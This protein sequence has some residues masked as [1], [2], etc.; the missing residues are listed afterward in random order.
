[1][2]YTVEDWNSNAEKK[3]GQK[4]LV[5]KTLNRHYRRVGRSPAVPPGNKGRP[6]VPTLYETRAKG[7][8]VGLKKN[9]DHT[10]KGKN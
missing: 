3:E 4:G 1:M 8:R 6:K 9:G 5:Q 2:A 10:R 7:S